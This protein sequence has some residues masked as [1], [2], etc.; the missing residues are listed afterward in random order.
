LI[1][2]NKILFSDSFHIPPLRQKNLL[3]SC[4]KVD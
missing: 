3:F 4:A 2:E 1:A